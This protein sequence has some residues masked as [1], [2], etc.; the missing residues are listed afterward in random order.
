MSRDDFRFIM[1]YVMIFVGVFSVTEA[2]KAQND[3]DAHATNP[4]ILDAT[5]SFFVG[6]R[7]IVQ[8]TTQVGLYDGGPIA[9]DQMYVQ[10][11]VPHGDTKPPIVMVHGATLTGASFET[12]PD[13]RMGWY[14]YF[15]RKGYPSYLVDQVGRGRSGFN[16]A[17]FN[18]VRAGL[19]QPGSQPLLRRVATDIAWVRFR[20]GPKAGVKFDDTQFPVEAAE[21]FAMQAVP[22]LAQSFPFDDPNY[23]ALSKLS[24]KLENVIL[25]GHSQAGRFPFETALLDPRGIRSLIAVEPPG[26]NSSGYSDEQIRRLAKLPILVVFGD[27]LEV[28]QS[29]GPNWLPFFKDCETFIAR[30][31]AVGGNAKM[32]HPPAI[33]INGNSHM[34]MQDKNNLQ[35]ADL[36]SEWINQN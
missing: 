24:R 13:G 28:P 29:V 17:P 16:Q 27:H 15:A 36:I 11:M 32:L 20:A 7:T 33:G 30:V 3:T 8:T 14:E 34:L 2:T 5:G 35:I 23:T 9:I 6:G 1:L 25:L 31:N 19:S 21:S 12:T 26:C 18:D 4:L 10:Y 22:D